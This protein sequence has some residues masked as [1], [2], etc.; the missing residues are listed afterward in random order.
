MPK[1]LNSIFC[2]KTSKA[3]YLKYYIS[4]D[5]TQD[6]QTKIGDAGV[7]LYMHYLRMASMKEPDFTDENTARSLNW[8]LRKVRR[9]RSALASAGYYKASKYTRSDGLKGIDHHLGVDAVAKV[10]K[11]T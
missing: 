8:N 4:Y 11:P 7:L 10:S 2:D 5:E 3:L 9:Y 6:L 1:P